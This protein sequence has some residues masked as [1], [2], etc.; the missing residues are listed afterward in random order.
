MVTMDTQVASRQLVAALESRDVSVRLAAALRA[1]CPYSDSTV[2]GTGHPPD[3]VAVEPPIHAC[4]GQRPP[5]TRF[6]ERGEHRHQV[7]GGACCQHEIQVGDQ[8]LVGDLAS[9]ERLLRLMDDQVAIA[10]SER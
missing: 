5:R 9:G 1:G 10:L 2:M 3:P 8:V 4:Q 6:R 7:G